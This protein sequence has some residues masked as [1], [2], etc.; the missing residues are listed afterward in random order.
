MNTK[1][2]ILKKD[3]G[4]ELFTVH[5]KGNKELADHISA[6][7]EFFTDCKIISVVLVGE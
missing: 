4:G 2:V 7:F 5:I 1:Y 3:K 6:C